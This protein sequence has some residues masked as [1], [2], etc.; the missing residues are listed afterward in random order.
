MKS[1]SKGTTSS[2]A[3]AASV[4][5]NS[6]SRR[7]NSSLAADIP[8]CA[9][10]R[11][12]KRSRLW[13]AAAGSMSRCAIISPPLT[14]SLVGAKTVSRGWRVERDHE[15]HPL[16]ADRD[17]LERFAR[18]AGFPDRDAFAQV[19]LVHLRNVQ[20]HYATLF[21][22]A[23]VIEAGRRTLLFPSEADDRETLD[24]LTEM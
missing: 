14:V 15:P 2:S 21:E 22:N 23:P 1:R 19:L 24:R 13:L 17:G 18:F 9:S 7:S 12:C 16:P 3:A 8:S 5:S 10:K 20:R 4:R 11:R 6:S